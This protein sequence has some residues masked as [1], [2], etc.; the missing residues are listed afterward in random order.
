MTTKNECEQHL[1]QPGV[2]TDECLH[3]AH[4]MM[5]DD[6]GDQA[7]Y[8][9]Y[10]GGESVGYDPSGCSRGRTMPVYGPH[11][12]QGSIVF[13]YEHPEDCECWADDCPA[14]VES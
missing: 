4:C 12:E 10:L 5:G 3:L 11:L 8:G 7:V 9:D 14:M 2:C 1:D 13:R 6:G